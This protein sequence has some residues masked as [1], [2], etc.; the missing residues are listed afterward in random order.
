MKKIVVAAVAAVGFAVMTHTAAAAPMLGFRVFEDGVLQGGLTTSGSGV[1]TAGITTP[2]FSVVTGIATGAPLIASP[3]FTAQTT[4]LSSNLTF[5]AGP[6]TIRVEFTQTDVP[7]IT[8]GGLFTSLVST[9]TANLLVRGDFIDTVT[10]TNYAS[11]SNVAFAT[12]TLLAT[13][14]YSATGANASPQIVTSLS[15]PDPFFSETIVFSAIFLAGGAS[16]QASSQI[17]A[18]PTPVPEPATL[19]MFGIGVL[20]LGLARRSRRRA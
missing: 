16:L 9:L 2:S 3:A 1:L 19:A 7:S 20:G 4:A 15:L 18:V 6:H 10:I 5:G 13:Q 8:A 12:S 17:D 11:A 14:T